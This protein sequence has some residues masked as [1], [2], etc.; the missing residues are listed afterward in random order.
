MA[1]LVQELRDQIQGEV[2]DDPISLAVYSVDASIYE[3]PPLAVVLPRSKDELIAAVRIATRHGVPIIPRGAATGIAGGCIGRGLV[4]DTSQYLNRILAIDSDKRTA[5]CEPG[6][7][8]NQLNNALAPMGL[9]LGPDTSTGNRATLGG[10]LANNSAGAR[11]LRYGKMVDHV[12]EVQVLLSNG[13][14]VRFRPIDDAQLATKLA[15][16]ST[17]G[18]IYR[19]VVRIRDEY[20]AD[21]KAHFPT[22]PRRASG[23]NLDELLKPGPLNLSKLIAGSEGTLGI[24]TEMQV[25]LAPMPRASGICVVQFASLDEA[26]DSV[27]RLLPWDPLALELIDE[28]I[29]AAGRASPSLT[30]QIG[31]INGSPKAVLIVEFEAATNHDVAAQITA[32]TDWAQKEKIGYSVTGLTQQQAMR[33][34]WSVRES[35]LGLLLSKRSYS[36]AIAFIEDVA[37]PPDQLRP[38]MNSFLELLHRHGKDAGVYGHVGA[39]CMH[40]R[41]YIDLRDSAE[42]A[43]MKHLQFETADLLLKHHGALSGE[44]GDGFV[45]SWLNEKMFGKRVYEAFRTLKHAFD[46]RGLMNPGK[47]I[48]TQGLTEHLRLHPET[49]PVAFQT[50]LHFDRE[51]GF[52]LAAD[53]CNG[54]GL[55]RK[56]EGL[57]CPSFQAYGDEFHTTRARAQSFRAILNGRLPEEAMSGQGLYHILEYCLECKGCKT[58]CPSQVDMAKMKSEFLYHYQQKHGVTLRT[59]LF[60]QMGRLYS[61]MSPFASFFNAFSNRSPSYWLLSALGIAPE[62]PLP[63]LAKQRFSSWW[64]SHQVEQTAFSRTVVLFNDTYTEF[65]HPEIG[66][67]AVQVLNALGYGVMIPPWTCCGRPLISKGL[68]EQ[69]RSQGQKLVDLLLPFARQKLPI[70]GLEPSCLSA[71]QDDYRDLVNRNQAEEV[72]SYCSSLE[73]FLAGQSLPVTNDMPI[74]VYTHTHCHQ[75]ALVGSTATSAVLAAL[76]GIKASEIDAGCCG[77]A[78]SFG[79]EK[80]HYAMSMQIGEHKLFPAVRQANPN[81]CIVACGF[82]CRSQI[83]QGTGRAAIHLAQLIAQ[84]LKHS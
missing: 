82:S 4:I 18:T 60:A 78:G 73:E 9:R 26:F 84:R 23:Y 39:S 81:A 83:K 71:L 67:A 3:I 12:L 50:F 77:L 57:M 22:M 41:P 29:V 16:N 80:E 56:R 20:G 25:R 13:E 1:T 11:S 19:E 75:K 52:T 53:L 7:V 21:I 24:V 42:V 58:Q 32:F 5:T 46:P 49:Q 66:Q 14:L 62:R 44:H 72:R 10:M 45:R 69:A 65:L 36:R 15:L 37:V 31:W 6:V 79:Y 8:Q 70:I 27:A 54:N 68:L 33:D 34:V 38:F 59:R 48:A 74:R 17:E 76:P 47:V 61:A 28:K 40:I 30:T 55:C 2:R 51:G 35:G 63:K 64:K 43:L